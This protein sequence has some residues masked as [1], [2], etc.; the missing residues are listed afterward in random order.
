MKLRSKA[1]SLEYFGLFKFEKRAVRENKYAQKLV[2]ERW[3]KINTREINRCPMRKIKSCV[4][5]STK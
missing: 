1:I 2:F 5:I 3:A 4:K